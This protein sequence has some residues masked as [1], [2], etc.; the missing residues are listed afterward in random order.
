MLFQIDYTAPEA[1]ENPP[2]M[3][4]RPDGSFR[5]IFF[6]FISEV[7]I[8]ID[9]VET[10]L[11]PGSCILYTPKTKQKFYVVNNRLNHDFIDF[12]TSD[13]SFFEKIKFPLNTPFNPKLSQ[14]ITS[15]IREVREEK[16]K[17]DLGTEY[18]LDS[19]IATLF[20]TISRKINYRL[21]V[22]SDVY[23]ENIKFQFDN[24][25]LSIY[26][27]PDRQ[28]VS[29]LAKS[30]GFSLPR[31]NAL[32]KTYFGTT[33]IHDLTKARVSRVDEL[34]KNGLST[35]EIVRRIGFSSQE[36][37]Y[38]WFKRYFHMTK[39]EYIRKISQEGEVK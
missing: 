7:V 8:D 16:R 29:S 34:V 11:E 39:E 26:E 32:Y 19:K 28:S 20:V 10:I 12:T 4:D 2:F 27:H 1:I 33:P 38:R 18:I 35:R 25:R 6:H 15:T 37:F 36:Y 13:P 17:A 3:I 30:S 31:F 5:Y 9:G 14:L 24:I 21:R 23:T 22:N